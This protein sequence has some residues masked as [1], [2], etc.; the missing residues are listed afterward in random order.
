MVLTKIMNTDITAIVARGGE[1]EGWVLGSYLGI[2]IG[3]E[4]SVIDRVQSK[5]A[6]SR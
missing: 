1:L 2:S 4:L 5:D 3:W 6:H